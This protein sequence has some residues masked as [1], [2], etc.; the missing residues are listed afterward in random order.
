MSDSSETKAST[1][2][3]QESVTLAHYTVDQLPPVKDAEIEIGTPFMAV[4]SNELAELDELS[5]PASCPYCQQLHPLKYGKTLTGV[6]DRTLAF[7]QCIENK[8]TYLVG[9]FGKRAKL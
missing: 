2:F 7:V 6:E 8:Q 3:E 5:D 4:G 9:V 1:A